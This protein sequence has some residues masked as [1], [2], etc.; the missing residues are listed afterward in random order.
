M[1]ETTLTLRQLN[2]TLLHRQ[3]LLA[4]QTIDPYSAVRRLGAMQSQLPN[5]PY[6]GL[7]ARL[8]DFQRADLTALMESRRV[9]RAPWNRSTLHLVT[10][11]D[12][13]KF[14]PLIAPALVRGMKSFHGR[15][16]DGLDLDALVSEA[17]PHLAEAPRSMGEVKDHLLKIYPDRMGEA[18]NY[19]ARTL[20]PLV[21]VPPGGTWGVGSMAKYALA[22][23]WL[24]ASGEAASLADFFR[25]YLTGYGPA[26]VMDFQ[27]WTG[28]TGLQKP[29][30]A[31][32]DAFTVYRDE[33]GR[34][35]WDVPGGDIING[36]A[37][38]PV[39]LV[40]EYDN[41]VIAH[42]DRRRILA[43]DDR[44]KVFL[45]AA[46]VLGTVLVDGF[47]AGVWKLEKPTKKLLRVVV[48]PFG[49]LSPS[50]R[51]AVA[52]ESERLAR[53]VDEAAACEVVIG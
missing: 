51:Q 23:Q 35:L 52:D 41:L 39:R 27:V 49:A 34:E 7:W 5:P 45:T 16:L 33:G 29:L 13:Q 48:E 4:R 32:R 38:A 28:L 25:H 46:R 6:L 47:V 50:D 40:P 18:L 21:Q 24:G 36:D 26:S 37:P 17:I 1:T 14:R 43:D 19:A 42:Q 3:M 10:D 30:A 9:V 22:E 31:H 15:N 8:D 11:E 44:K 20:I 2:R 53:W 12:H